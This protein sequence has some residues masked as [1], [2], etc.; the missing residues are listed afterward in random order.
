MKDIYFYL[1]GEIKN[2]RSIVTT[3]FFEWFFIPYPAPPKGGVTVGNKK[4][5]IFKSF[6]NTYQKSRILY[7]FGTNIYVIFSLFEI[8]IMTGFLNW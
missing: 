6:T 5:Y 4:N 7:I 2:M 3:Q 1:K 8:K